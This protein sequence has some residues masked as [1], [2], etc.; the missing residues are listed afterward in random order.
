MKRIVS[1]LPIFVIIVMVVFVS[2]SKAEEQ[3]GLKDM[4]QCAFDGMKG[5]KSGMKAQMEYQGKTYYFC[6]KEERDK[7][8]QEPEKYLRRHKEMHQETPGRMHEGME[9]HGEYHQGHGNTREGRGMGHGSGHGGM[10]GGSGHRH[11]H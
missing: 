9:E 2:I 1:F 7:F 10:Y 3:A 11:G 4:V 8:A 6:T 5:P